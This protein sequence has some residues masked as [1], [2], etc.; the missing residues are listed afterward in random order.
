MH[1][2]IV[3]EKLFDNSLPC[4][5]LR[6]VGRQNTGDGGPTHRTE[7]LHQLLSA[8]LTAGDVVAGLEDGVAL[9]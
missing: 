4:P 5:S 7:L 2:A 6:D 1:A 3:N 9:R 8:G